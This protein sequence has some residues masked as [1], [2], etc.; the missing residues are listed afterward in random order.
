MA[1]RNDTGTGLASPTVNVFGSPCGYFQYAGLSL[2]GTAKGPLDT[3]TLTV[4][5]Q[6][7]STTTVTMRSVGGTLT[8]RVTGPAVT[9]FGPI[10][11]NVGYNPNGTDIDLVRVQADNDCGHASTFDEFPS[12]ERP[13]LAISGSENTLHFT[14]SNLLPNAWITINCHAGDYAN[15]DL[16]LGAPIVAHFAVRTDGNGDASAGPPRTCR[17]RAADG[18]PDG[19]VA[20][21]G[22]NGSYDDNYLSN[23][24]PLS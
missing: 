13:V 6:G 16:D 20:L 12:F 17:L 19:W 2:T 14:G 4:D 23:S 11:D 18:G 9:T 22:G 3:F 1:I 5:P 24:I 8:F 7:G 15:Q 21:G 10:V